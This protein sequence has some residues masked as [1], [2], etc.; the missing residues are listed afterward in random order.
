MLQGG[1]PAMKHAGSDALDDLEPLV[2]A[3]RGLAG[4]KEK[5][6]GVFYRRGRAFLHFHEDAAGLFCDVRLEPAEDFTRFRVSSASERKA[7][8]AKVK[9]VLDADGAARR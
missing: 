3:I 2:A 4:L 9:A 5:Q 8:L 6:R 7:L 1:G